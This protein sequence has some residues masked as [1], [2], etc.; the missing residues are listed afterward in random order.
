MTMT[1]SY[2]FQSRSNLE[3]IPGIY[4]ESKEIETPLGSLTYDS[5]EIKII[6]TTEKNNKIK[7]K[8]RF[9]EGLKKTF[10]CTIG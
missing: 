6:S 5:S 3:D 1:N 9:L 7:I 8:Y 2:V 10:I 4:M